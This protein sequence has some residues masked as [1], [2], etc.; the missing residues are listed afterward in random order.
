[1][2]VHGGDRVEVARGKFTDKE[3]IVDMTRLQS[4]MPFLQVKASKMMQEK[5]VSSSLYQRR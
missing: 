1:V 3:S 5:Q 4:G 2:F